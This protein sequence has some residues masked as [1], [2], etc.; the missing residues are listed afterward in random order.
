MSGKLICSIGGDVF[1]NLESF[2][3]LRKLSLIIK[4]Y[5]SSETDQENAKDLQGAVTLLSSKPST[6]TLRDI[7]VNCDSLLSPYGRKSFLGQ[8]RVVHE[9][10]GTLLSEPYTST[11][12]VTFEVSEPIKKNEA[13]YVE[14]AIKTAFPRMQEK[15]LL[16][17]VFDRA[18]E[19]LPSIHTHDR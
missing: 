5:S 12:S 15:G 6:S 1:L 16:H 14:E 13:W 4:R 7:R 11:V 19:L 8:D 2:P 18:C 10:E 17:I 3:R 9:L